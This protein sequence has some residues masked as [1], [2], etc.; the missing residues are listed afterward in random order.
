MSNILLIVRREL[1]S[2]ARTPSGYVI[3]A[4]TLLIV[5]VFLLNF[6]MFR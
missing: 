5:N 4:I 1:A 3:A 2:Y 6:L